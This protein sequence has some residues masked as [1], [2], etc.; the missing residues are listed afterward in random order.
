MSIAASGR[1][2]A[3]LSRDLGK[4]SVQNLQLVDRRISKGDTH[5]HSILDIDNRRRREECPSIPC[6]AK[7]DLGPR[8]QSI[9]YVDETSFAADFRNSPGKPHIAHWFDDF[10]RG[11]EFVPGHRTLFAIRSRLHGRI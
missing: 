1:T 4:P 2:N 7:I 5:A 8:G 11:D 6:D 3:I 9:Q 10:N